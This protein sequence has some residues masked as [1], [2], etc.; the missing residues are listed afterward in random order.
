MASGTIEHPNTI[1]EWTPNLPRSTYTEL[2][3]NKVY[4]CGN[5]VICKCWFKIVSSNSQNDYI[6]YTSFPTFG[7]TMKFGFGFW[8]DNTKSQCGFLVASANNNAWFYY[9]NQESSLSGRV[10]SYI[11]VNFI[12]TV[13]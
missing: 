6:D 5:I 2:N 10:N 13:I 7:K 3:D 4:K 11:L 12:Y 9:N 1:V 8:M